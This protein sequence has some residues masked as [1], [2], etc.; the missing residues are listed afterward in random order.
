MVIDRASLAAIGLPVKEQLAAILNPD[1]STVIPSTVALQATAPSSSAGA[2]AA[3]ST[4]PVPAAAAKSK[5]KA[6]SESATA[7]VAATGND[8]AK[9]KPVTTDPVYFT[10]T[11]LFELD[12]CEILEA[13][14]PAQ[15]PEGL[16]E[17]H[18]KFTVVLNRTIFHPQGGGQPAD[19]GIL[20]SKSLPEIS[21]TMVSMRKEDG[22]V[23]HDCTVEPA[24]ADAWLAKVGTANVSCRVD[25]D[26]RRLAARV[27]SAGHLLDVAVT[28]VGLKWIP[29]KGYHF[30][31]GP[32]VEYVLNDESRRIDPKKAGDKEAIIAD[33]QANIDRLVT[34][35]GKVGVEYQDGVRR[36]RMGDEECPCGGTHVRDFAE[37]GKV[38]VKKVQN[39]QGNVRLAY[40]VS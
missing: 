15:Q 16:L 5:A 26:R 37:I 25:A 6:T 11:Y 4:A 38:Q 20:S 21:V 13:F 7:P 40:T 29:S 32:Y 33:I 14:R 27:H 10:D 12:G 8:P 24:Q 2:K 30:P 1:A 17:G 23:L 19:N 39:K 36:I 22:A 34:E 28:A 3:T 31:D 35:G 9:L 18:V